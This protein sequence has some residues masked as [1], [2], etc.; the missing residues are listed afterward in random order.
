MHWLVYRA[1]ETPEFSLSN[2]LKIPS[3][4]GVTWRI[5]VSEK[6]PIPGYL[7]WEEKG[8][9]LAS[10]QGKWRLDFQSYWEHWQREAPS[11]RKE[12]LGK[13]L[14]LAQDKAFKILDAT[15]GTAKDAFLLLYW[16]QEVYG[17]ERNPVVF[18]LLN[19]AYQRFI[20]SGHP[21]S[22][23][24]RERFHLAYGES[25]LL[26]SEVDFE[27]IY[28]DPMYSSLGRKSSALGRK[29][30]EGL[31]FLLGV[32]TDDREVFL[33]LWQRCPYVV[34]KRGPLSP[35]LDERVNAQWKSKALRLDKYLRS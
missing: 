15:L 31:K 23:E 14:G 29:E 30:M 19:D 11:I 5:K 9:F 25:S 4:A 8:L 32:D 33:M 34:V 1:P 6:G 12:P 35:A 22:A 28:Y 10:Q 21:F 2:K 7:W 26:F 17:A 20:K 18:V 16:G 13:A 3:L 24:L 27:R